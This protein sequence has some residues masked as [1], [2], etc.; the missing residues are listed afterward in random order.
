ML[1]ARDTV[2]YRGRACPLQ[3]FLL[4]VLVTWPY[5]IRACMVG[6]GHMRAYQ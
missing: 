4:H 2:I 3:D 5:L 6:S 1:S